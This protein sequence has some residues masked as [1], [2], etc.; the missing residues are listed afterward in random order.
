MTGRIP[1]PLPMLPGSCFSLRSDPVLL[2]GSE[3][4]ESLYNAASYSSVAQLTK[5][6]TFRSVMED[7]RTEVLCAGLLIKSPTK[8][9]RKAGF[10]KF[11]KVRW[12]VLQRITYIGSR[13][14]GSKLAFCYYKNEEEFRNEKLPY[15][16]LKIC[17]DTEI[18]SRYKS[19]AG[20]DHLFSIKRPGHTTMKLSAPSCNL[21]SH[22]ITVLYYYQSI[23]SPKD[24]PNRR[25]SSTGR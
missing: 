16:T 24:S 22:W 8:S 15:N 6:Q 23:C 9:E 7:R 18:R 13:N 12:C 3:L 1:P 19:Q 14:E 10:S 17:R 2:L 20:F 5:Q 11:W 4:T 21:K 25:R